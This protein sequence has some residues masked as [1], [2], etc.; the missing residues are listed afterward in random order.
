MDRNKGFLWVGVG[1]P[2]ACFLDCC[3]FG[4]CAPK[5]P[6]SFRTSSIVYFVFV[7]YLLH[8]LLSPIV[9]TLGADRHEARHPA[10][11][12]SSAMVRS[13]NQLVLIALCCF[14]VFTCPTAAAEEGGSVVGSW[15]CVT[16]CAARLHHSCCSNNGENHLL[17]LAQADW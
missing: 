3:S 1:N 4:C 14:S 11:E 15:L 6:T 13:I 10:A 2:E 17:H 12:S 7:L 8:L 5:G 16:L 9:C